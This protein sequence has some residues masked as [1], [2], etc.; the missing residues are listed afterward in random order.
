MMEG[1]RKSGL[2]NSSDFSTCCGV[3]VGEHQYTCSRCSKV[4]R[5]RRKV[6]AAITFRNRRK[7]ANT[8]PQIVRR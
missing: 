3:Y 1:V 2:N 7:I 6:D 5:N 8:F 4:V